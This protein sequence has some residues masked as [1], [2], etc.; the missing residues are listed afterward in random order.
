MTKNKSTLVFTNSIEEL[1]SEKLKNEHY[2]TVF[3]LVDNNTKELCLPLIENS[4]PAD[5]RLIEIKAGE[6]HKT[7]TTSLDIWQILTN[8]HADRSALMINL[9][10]GVICDM[11][12][13]CAR[14]YKRGIHFWNIPTTLLSQVD[15]SVGGKLGVDFGLFKN[16]IGLFSEPDMVML[17]S[18]FFKTLPKDELLSGFAEM[19]K[20][21]LIRDKKMFSELT[22]M[23]ID[24]IDWGKWIPHSVGIKKEI[25]DQDPT[26]K[27]LRKLLNYGHTIGHAIE[28]Y[29]MVKHD[30]LKHGEAIAIGMIT[31][32]HVASTREML[33]GDDMDSINKYLIKTFK[34]PAIDEDGIDSI[35]NLALQDK[36]NKDGKINAVLLTGIGQAKIDIEISEAEI[37]ASLIYYN[38]LV[39]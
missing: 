3:V 11:G 39:K 17:D 16:H 37:K 38:D 31:E 25:V 9:G 1:V 4:L 7:L 30:M 14:T 23:N 22:K 18:I 10:G 34:H 36:K 19:V 21:A 32:N 33:S 5:Y 29:H 24:S 8:A 26:E 27:G 15:A 35:I 20:H 12:G 13:F 6:V 28:S 2:S